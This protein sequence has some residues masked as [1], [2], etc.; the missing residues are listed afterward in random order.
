M[1]GEVVLYLC[2]VLLVNLPGTADEKMRRG[3]WFFLVG[4]ALSILTLVMSFFG[5]G[6]KRVGFALASIAALPFWFGFTL[7]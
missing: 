3:A 2:G 6:W 1:L 7:Y 4:T 5:Y